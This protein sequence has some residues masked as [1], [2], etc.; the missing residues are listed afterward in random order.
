[1]TRLGVDTRGNHSYTPADFVDFDNKD[2][3]LASGSGAID[4]GIILPGINDDY[5]GAAPDAGALKHGEEMWAVGRNFASPPNPVYGWRQL[6]GTNAFRNS[7]F[8]QAPE[9]WTHVGTPVWLDRNAWNTLGTGLSRRGRVFQL[10]PGDGIQRQ[11][12]GLRPDTWYAIA[13]EARLL[14]QRIEMELVGS[15]TNVTVGDHRG[16]NYAEGVADGQ[17][18]RFDGVDFGPTGKYDKLELTYSRPPG[19]SPSGSPGSVQT[20]LCNRRRPPARNRDRPS[21]AIQIPWPPRRISPIAGGSSTW[22]AIPTC[23]ASGSRP[24]STS[25]DDSAM[26]ACRS[27]ARIRAM[28]VTPCGRGTTDGSSA[29]SG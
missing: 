28:A 3:R 17:W 11:L 4:T 10:Q 16:E 12:T 14:D 18:L 21:M 1:M 20:S 5:R 23:L 24:R 8:G 29:G 13:S 19:T 9:G 26:F 15:S 25:L 2:F 7:Q 22:A 27:T 6:P